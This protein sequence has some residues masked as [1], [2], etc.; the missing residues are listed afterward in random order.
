[1]SVK[2]RILRLS[3]SD[4]T[5]ES[6]SL[7]YHKLHDPALKTYLAFVSSNRKNEWVKKERDQDVELISK[8]KPVEEIIPIHISSWHHGS[9][10]FRIK[11]EDG[12]YFV[13]KEI[14]REIVEREVSFFHLVDGSDEHIKSLFPQLYYFSHEND[15]SYIISSYIDQIETNENILRKLT[16]KDQ[17][18]LI[19]QMLDLVRWMR[20]VGVCHNDIRLENFFFSKGRLILFDFGYSCLFQNREAFL[21]SLSKEELE[22]LNKHNRIGKYES[23]DIFSVFYI[24][25]EICPD[26]MSQYRDI[27]SEINSYMG[28]RVLRK[29]I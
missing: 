15:A 5:K 8:F 7:V 3:I 22:K 27:W 24:M 25:K 9:A 20:K 10:Y 19:Y 17:E 26:F 1:M 28:E 18:V 6:L 21:D 29:I 16:H 13:K 12:I 2:S 23:D 4:S 14:N 11:T